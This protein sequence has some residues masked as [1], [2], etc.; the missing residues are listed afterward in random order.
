MPTRNIN[1]T[2]HFDNFVENLVS[3]GRFKNASEVMRAG[4][5]LL[6]KQSREDEEKLEL[7]RKLAAEGFD[8]LHRGE[9]IELHSDEELK[10][11]IAEIGRR[12]G[13]RRKKQ[14]LG[15]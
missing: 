3:A 15:G 9:G 5:H 8:Q 7:L 13:E 12:V 14:S 1:L 4:L 2:E 10:E 6:E 11:Y